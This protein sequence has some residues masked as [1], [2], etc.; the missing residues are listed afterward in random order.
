[1]I[2]GWVGCDWVGGDNFYVLYFLYNDAI[3]HVFTKMSATS[4]EKRTDSIGQSG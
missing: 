1:M 4:N 2:I 3:L